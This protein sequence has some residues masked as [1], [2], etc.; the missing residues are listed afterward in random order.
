MKFSGL[1]L[2][3]IFFQNCSNTVQQPTIHHDTTTPKSVDSISKENTSWIYDSLVNRNHS[4]YEERRIQI[5]KNVRLNDSVFYVLY[6]V[7]S[8]VNRSEY[9][10]TF[11]HNKPQADEMISESPDADFSIPQYDYTE[12]RLSNDTLFD[13]YHYDQEVKY[14]EKVLTK[15]G[16]FKEG[17][18]FENVDIKTDTTHS[19]VR[20]SANGF[21]KRDTIK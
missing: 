20:I 2:I 18:D 11:I 3:I 8:P 15:E 6:S 19:R 12:Y 4:V 17:F 21:I 13:V 1:V 10:L 5:E 16:D 7:N 9:V 14:P